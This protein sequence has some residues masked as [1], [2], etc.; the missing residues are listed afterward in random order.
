MPKKAR[1]KISL[2]RK[3]ASSKRSEGWRNTQDRDELKENAQKR[4]EIAR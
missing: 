4:M 3:T 2:G 1:R